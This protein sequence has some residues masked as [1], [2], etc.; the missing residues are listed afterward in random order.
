VC[1]N[2]AEYIYIFHV[3]HRLWGLGTYQSTM[4]TVC[5]YIQSLLQLIVIILSTGASLIAVL[6][7]A[8]ET[9]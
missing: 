3:H 8:A 7:P 1:A 2:N 6:L 4:W 9:L 5:L